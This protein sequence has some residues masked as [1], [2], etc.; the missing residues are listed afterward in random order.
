MLLLTVLVWTLA[1]CGS[2]ST[3]SQ[4]TQ[5]PNKLSVTS[6]NFGLIP[7]ED[8]TKEITDTKALSDAL[9][10]KL[11]VPI[12][13]SVA[14]SYTAL[15]ESMASKK[16]DVGWFGPFSYILAHSKYGVDFSVR[17]LTTDGAPTYN[18]LI[19]TTP[20]TGITTLQELKGHTFSYV[21]PAST[22]GNLVPRYVLTKAGLNPDTDVHGSF[23]GNHTA[24]ITAIV[25]HK[26]DAGAV[27]SDTFAA[28]KAQGLFKDSDVVIIDK[29]FDIPESPIGVRKDLTANDKR[30]IKAA[31][32]SVTD[33]T[34]LTPSGAGGFVDGS[35]ADYNGLRDVATT[36][37]IDVGSLVK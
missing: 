1:A 19:V 15:I 29:S 28:V 18:S 12:N 21:D 8:S 31:F 4:A 36:L 3:A 20:Q 9:S 32:L 26:V 35:D 5:D 22:S 24:S 10:K 23:A 11:G 17:Q 13:L 7:T 27:A 6:L 33:K 34:I 30:L 14:T 2:S 37:G 25:S 16:V